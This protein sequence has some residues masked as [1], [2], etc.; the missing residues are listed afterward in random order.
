MFWEGETLEAPRSGTAGNPLFWAAFSAESAKLV[1]SFRFCFAQKFRSLRVR[2]LKNLRR[3]GAVSSAPA[4][5]IG[6]SYLDSR[7]ASA[8]FA[9]PSA[10]DV[11]SGTSHARNGGMHASAG[12]FRKI[13]NRL[14]ALT[15]DF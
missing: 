1:F 14:Q 15:L 7:L 12:E 2:L 10:L 9:L 5:A 3:K 6:S 4:A 13:V 11:S 8:A